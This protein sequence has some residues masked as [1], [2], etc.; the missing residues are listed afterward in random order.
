MDFKS[1][2]LDYVMNP[3]L[4]ALLADGGR[5]GLAL[6]LKLGPA[7]RALHHRERAAAL[8]Q[9]GRSW[10]VECKIHQWPMAI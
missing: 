9:M 10:N 5:V 4:L 2:K 8:L 6:L 1:D 7:V 3:S